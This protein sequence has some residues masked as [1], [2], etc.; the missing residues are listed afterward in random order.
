[1]STIIRLLSTGFLK[2]VLIAGCIA[3]P[4]SYVVGYLFLNIFANR[5]SLGIT[6]QLFSLLG[7]LFI[8]LLTMGSQIFRVAVANPVDALRNE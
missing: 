8:A 4:V 3:L 5:I 7:L 6:V 1:V 2:L